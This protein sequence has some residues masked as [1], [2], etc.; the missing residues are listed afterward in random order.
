[1]SIRHSVILAALAVMSV[2]AMAGSKPQTTLTASGMATTD[3]VLGYCRSVNAISVAKYT[4]AINSITQGHP[5]EELFDIRESKQ[6]KQTLATLN[7][8][9]LKVPIATGVSACRAGK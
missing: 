9:L 2:S 6:Y 8:Q 7:S 4:Q 1:M 3:G 5:R